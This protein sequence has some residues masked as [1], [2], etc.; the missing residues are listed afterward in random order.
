MLLLEFSISHH[1]NNTNKY[2]FGIF[3][4]SNAETSMTSTNTGLA[5]NDCLLVKEN[6]WTYS[7]AQDLAFCMIS[8]F[9]IKKDPFTEGRIREMT[10]G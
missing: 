10:P 9:L 5:L 2:F 4:D 6:T 8:T 3:Q 7:S 1:G